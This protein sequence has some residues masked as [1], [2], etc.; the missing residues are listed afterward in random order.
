MKVPAFTDR[1]RG[2]IKYLI[3]QLGSDEAAFLLREAIEHWGFLRSHPSLSALPPT[4]T[5]GALFAYRETLRAYLHDRGK[6]VVKKTSA[7]EKIKQYEKEAV[8]KVPA[9]MSLTEMVKAARKE[10]A[11]GK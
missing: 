8:D 9:K 3:E 5:F 10:I 4:P 1:E 2:N 6:V 11:N 7:V